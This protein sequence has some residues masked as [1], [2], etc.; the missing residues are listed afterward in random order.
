MK[1]SKQITALTLS[2]ALLAAPAAAFADTAYQ[3]PVQ[4]H[5]A[6]GSG[7][8]SMASAALDPTAEATVKDNGTT[9]YTIFL[10]P[11]NLQGLTGHLTNLFVYKGGDKVE[12]VR[13]A[14]AGEYKT[15]M[16]FSRDTAKEGDIKAAVWVDAMD[17]LAGGTPGA[18]EQDAI[19]HFD[20]AQA[21]VVQETAAPGAG[22]VQPVGQDPIQVFVK[23]QKLN[24]DS[25]PV[26]QNG[27]TLVP[28]R[29]IFEALGADVQWDNATR[30]V[31]ATKD[32]HTIQLTIDRTEVSVDGAKKTLDV[33]ATIQNSRT[34]VP[35]RFIG[36]AFGNQV[37][38]SKT[39]DIALIAIQ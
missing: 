25:Q 36:E 4:L 19:L 35:L 38:Y 10:R 34:L 1:L 18:G 37:D 39:G 21:K 22:Q 13:A 14:H 32:G 20:W 16:S 15:A 30:T 24:F 31:T 17:Q 3:V 27:R 23:G 29:A 33:P 26:I 8:T 9:D 12:A 28:L 5:K 2:L 11:I 7:K 6:D